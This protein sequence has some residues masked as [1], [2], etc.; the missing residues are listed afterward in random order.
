MAYNNLFQTI[1]IGNVTISNRI[2]HVPTDVSY[3]TA[4]GEVTN[5]CCTYH[6]EIAKG[7]CGFIIVGASSPDRTTGRTS[8]T[9]VS[10]DEDYFIPGLHRL[11][12]SMQ[13]HGAKCA[14]QI[15]HPG[16]QAVFPRKR[17]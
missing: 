2:V 10:V 14:V 17:L 12:T 4:F 3:N 1:K 8:V 9:C 15:M 16:R 6:G 5:R 13:K 7:G 11:A